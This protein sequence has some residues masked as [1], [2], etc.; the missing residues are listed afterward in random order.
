MWRC[1]SRIERSWQRPLFGYEL[2]K[3]FALTS[4][5]V[6]PNLLKNNYHK[7]FAFR[8]LNH[9]FFLCGNRCRD[10]EKK[11]SWI[12]FGLISPFNAT[13]LTK[14]LWL[15]IKTNLNPPLR[16]IWGRADNDRWLLTL[17]DEAALNKK[18]PGRI[19]KEKNFFFRFMGDS[20]L[21]NEMLSRDHKENVY[22]KTC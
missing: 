12:P 4:A 15:L 9:Y 8:R 7:N 1:Y 3:I 11:I 18:C 20:K 21:K 2:L 5:V 10:L 17:S 16:M 14:L 6:N 22:F 19:S 13:I